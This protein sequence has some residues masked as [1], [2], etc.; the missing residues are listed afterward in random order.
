M[1][2]KLSFKSGIVDIFLN[3]LELLRHNPASHHSNPR[4]H[5]LLW[6]KIRHLLYQ[7]IRRSVL[8]KQK[9]EK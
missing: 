1:K 3:S 5:G 4:S 9:I 7:A 2:E 6:L 8:I